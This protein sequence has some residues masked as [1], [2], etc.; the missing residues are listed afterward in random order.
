MKLFYDLMEKLIS[1]ESVEFVTK[2]QWM[3]DVW[4]KKMNFMSNQD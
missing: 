1:T 2:M 3:N 4:K